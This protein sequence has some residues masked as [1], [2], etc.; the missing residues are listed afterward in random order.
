MAEGRGGVVKRFQ[1]AFLFHASRSGHQLNILEDGS[2]L[3]SH[4]FHAARGW[5]VRNQI[6]GGG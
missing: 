1:Y 6:G 2:V 5:Q 4:T 3:E